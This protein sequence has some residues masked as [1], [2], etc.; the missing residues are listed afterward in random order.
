LF[1]EKEN[2]T[3]K[4]YTGAEYDELSEAEKARAVKTASL[5]SRTEPAHKMALVK[6]LQGQGEVVAMTGDGVNDAPALKK[7]DIGIAMGSGT[8]VAKEAS[9]IFIYFLFLFLFLKNFFFFFFFF[10]SFKTWF[11]LMITLPP[12]CPLWRRVAQSSTTQNN[13]FVT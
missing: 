9:G 1:E 12:L 5:F 4:S 7:A 10:P 13:S 11:W 2:L 3:G 6:L 8:A